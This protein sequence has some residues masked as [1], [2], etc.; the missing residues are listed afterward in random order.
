MDPLEALGQELGLQH[1]YQPRPGLAQ[2]GVPQPA[3]GQQCTPTAQNRSPLDII[4]NSENYYIQRLNFFG[5]GV[6][7]I[8]LIL[9]G[10]VWFWSAL[11]AAV[12]VGSK[13][14]GQKR[15]TRN[16]TGKPVER[17]FIQ[18][19]LKPAHNS[20]YCRQSPYG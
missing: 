1:L 19:P 17:R 5:L 8:I 16:E 11:A 12:W 13:S 15:S 4:L 2:P 18:P 10:G 3:A 7:V 6:A 14:L 9:A 20:G